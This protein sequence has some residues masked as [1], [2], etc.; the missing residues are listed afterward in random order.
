M[1]HNTALLQAKVEQEKRCRLDVLVSLIMMLFCFCFLCGSTIL[2]LIRSTQL[3]TK[4]ETLSMIA[5]IYCGVLFLLICYECL[6]LG[7]LERKQI[8]VEIE[9]I[10]NESYFFWLT[11]QA[12]A[13]EVYRQA[14][15]MEYATIIPFG[16][17]DYKITIAVKKII[18]AVRYPYFAGLLTATIVNILTCSPAY[19]P[20]DEKREALIKQISSSLEDLGDWAITA[21]VLA[22][23]HKK[24]PELAEQLK[25][26]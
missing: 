1:T 11:F 23:I 13:E 4:N 5:M 15:N 21:C 7:W 22:G 12:P 3:D 26:A 14:I 25:N 24:N 8:R 6:R 20:S 19:H 10:K 16:T 2:F 18:A 9:K 17:D